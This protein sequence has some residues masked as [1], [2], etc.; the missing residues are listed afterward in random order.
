MPKRR[1]FTLI[2]LLV[3]VTIIALLIAL[4]LPAVQAAREAARRAQCA[5][6]LKQLGLA[7]QN[8][9]S[10]N[11][12]FPAQ[13]IWPTAGANLTVKTQGAFWGFNWYCALLPQMEQQAIFNAINFS[14]CPM[15]NGP[16]LASMFT[17]ATSEIGALLCPS[18]SASTQ[19]LPYPTSV[20]GSSDSGFYSVS[21]YVGNYGGPAAL[22]PYSGTIIPGWDLEQGLMA[23][24]NKLPAV[25]MQA[26]TDGTSSTALFSE[27]LLSQYP[28]L[29]NGSRT[30]ATVYANGIAGLRAIFIGP[31]AAPPNSVAPGA[32][33]TSNTAYL[34]AQGCQSIGSSIPAELPASMGIT[35]LTGGPAFLGLSSY[36]HWTVP[37]TPPC[38]N[39][40]DPSVQDFIGPYGAPSANSLHPG[41]V[42]VC[43]ADGSVHF[44]KSSIS[45]PAWWCLGTRS[46]GEVISSDQY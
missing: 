20:N 24:S 34:F 29:S 42:N 15:D 4:L 43:F 23:T 44:V 6:N 26:I 17:A 2:E 8:Y 31:V 12:V 22:T 35:M 28:Y 30:K 13:S 5:N 25:G 41:G 3:V 45:L 11:N 19:L 16:G 38:I 32:P 1:G 7:A 39:P 33:A 9:V 46:G 36:V 18:E 14:L 27:R 10:S 37:N 21:N 40:S